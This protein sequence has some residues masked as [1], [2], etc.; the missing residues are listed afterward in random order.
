MRN[1]S[2]KLRLASLALLAASAL[3]AQDITLPPSGD[4]QR[5]TVSQ[6]IGPVILTVDYSSPRVKRIGQADRRGKIWG[7]LVPYGTTNLGFGTCK[8]C[9]WRAGANENTTFAATRD[10]L[11]EG[12]KLAAGVYGL[13]MIP[14]KEEWTVIFS[15]DSTSWG[16]FFYDPA[17]DALRVTVKPSVSEYHEFLTYEFP[18]RE[19]DRAVL[20]LKWEDLQV[21]I[22][23]TVPDITDVYIAEIRKELKNSKGFDW[24]NW[25]AAS[26]YEIDHQKNLPE[27]LAWA[28]NAVAG[29]VGQENFTTLMALA[30]AQAANGLAAE[31][32]KTRELAFNHPTAGAIDLHLYGR[33][34][35]AAGKKDEAMKV[36][37]LNAKRHGS[38]W[39]VNVG[40]ARGYSA[41][42]KYKEALKYARLA[43]PQAP[44]PGNKKALEDA[45][46]KLE[47][48]QDMNG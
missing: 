25:A 9:P 17:Q 6:H 34:L 13:H 46:K 32:Q 5:A 21:P 20:A 30:D 42:G 40:L 45:A 44:D 48:G 43:V 18:V 23:I 41:M 4:N 10:V 16:S 33:Q 37:L 7:Q 28:K 29:A 3:A 8:E 38:A 22:S 2:T 19:P 12:Q 24:R 31:S 36:W 11:V 27:A 35:L 1:P 47:A 15:N 39:P 26:K 14:G